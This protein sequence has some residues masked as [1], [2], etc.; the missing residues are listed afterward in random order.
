MW[1]ARSPNWTAFAD[2][3]DPHCG[4]F[5][6]GTALGATTEASNDRPCPGALTEEPVSRFVAHLA[7]G[8]RMCFPGSSHPKKSRSHPA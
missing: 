1:K 3:V 2:P 7:E 5:T 8:A 6:I 4:L